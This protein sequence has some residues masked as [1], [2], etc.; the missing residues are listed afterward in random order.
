VCGDQ[1]ARI[2]HLVKL[3]HKNGGQNTRACT[4]RGILIKIIG[5]Q[6]KGSIKETATKKNKKKGR[7]KKQK[8]KKKKKKLVP[9]HYYLNVVLTLGKTPF[10]D[11]GSIKKN[12]NETLNEKRGRAVELTRSLHLL[13]VVQERESRKDFNAKG[14]LSTHGGGRKSGNDERKRGGCCSNMFTLGRKKGLSGG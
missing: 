3:F 7:T 13:A 9:A 4:T 6:K 14:A 11:V 2:R 8:K 1:G 10:K 12:K 5:L